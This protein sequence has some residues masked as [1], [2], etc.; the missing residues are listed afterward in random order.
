[1]DHSTSP[2]RLSTMDRLG[3]AFLTWRRYLQRRIAAHDITLKQSF[4]LRQLDR[5]A[6]LL[7]SQIANM[8]FCDRPTATVI[9]R[10]LEK[11]GWVE[12]QTDDRDRR[13]KRVTITVKGRA[14]HAEVTQ[15]V[16][17][18][19]SSAFD[20]LGCLTEGEKQTFERLLAKVDDHLGQIRETPSAS[21]SP[22]R[23]EP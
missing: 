16:W 19:M 14:K 6:F 21:I 5:R 17:S 8:L 7:P 20:P 12:R 23:R 4:V 22:T 3:I 9:I 15:H 11:R 1:M 10:N 13:Q 2:T 18:S